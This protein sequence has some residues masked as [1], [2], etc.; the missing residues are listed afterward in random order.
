MNFFFQNEFL[1]YLNKSAE[2]TDRISS[3]NPAKSKT[4]NQ[5]KICSKLQSHI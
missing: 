3:S 4:I 1:K 2:E 5:I